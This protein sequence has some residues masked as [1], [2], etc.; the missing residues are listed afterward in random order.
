MLLALANQCLGLEIVH[1]PSVHNSL[2][3][4]GDTAPPS[5]YPTQDTK[6]HSPNHVPA[7]EEIE[8]FGEQHQ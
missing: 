7:R 8:M 5:W 6:K 1:A 3:R 4:A 2:A